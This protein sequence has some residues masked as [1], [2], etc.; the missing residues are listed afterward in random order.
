MEIFLSQHPKKSRVH[1]A[2]VKEKRE[3]WVKLVKLCERE[4]IEVKIAGTDE[5]EKI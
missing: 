4:K 5:N 3:K 1:S 2:N